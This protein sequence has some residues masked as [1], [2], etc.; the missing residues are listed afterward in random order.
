MLC[1]CPWHDDKGKPNLYINAV[2]GPYLCHA[3]GAKGHLRHVL[4]HLPAPSTSDLREKMAALKDTE[5]EPGR[6]Y[7]EDW[8]T[9]FDFPHAYWDSRGFTPE[10]IAKFQLGFDPVM[11]RVTIPLRTV[12]GRLLGVV[13][14]VLTD[15]KP[16]YRY[17][18]GFP[19]GKHL[20]GQWLAHGRR[21]VALVEGSLDAIACWDARVPALALLGS[22]LTESQAQVLVRLGVHTVAIFTDNDTPGQEA[23]GQVHAQLHRSGITTQV[24][25]YRPYWGAKDPGEL[26]PHQRRKAYHSAIPW[27]RWNE[28]GLLVR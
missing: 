10:M 4:E 12:D 26:Q 16:K 28:Q 7:S 14:R 24:C 2:D 21:K 17:P 25:Q 1:M 27:H 13:Q 18:R 20:F 11:D 6:I 8:L 15:E 5:L 9:R 3:C 23:V 22:R 19:I